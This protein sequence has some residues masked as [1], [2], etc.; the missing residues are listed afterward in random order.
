M[1]SSRAHWK[2]LLSGRAA[3]MR[4][5]GHATAHWGGPVRAM[6]FRVPFI[7]RRAKHQRLEL[8]GTVPLLYLT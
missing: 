8:P 7:G 5:K 2:M 1:P 6:E 3:P 4:K